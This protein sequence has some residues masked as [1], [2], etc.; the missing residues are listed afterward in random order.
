MEI[1]SYLVYL[2]ASVCFIFGIKKLSS[3][4]TARRGNQLAALGMLIAIV[5]TLLDQRILTF[6]YIILGMVVGGLVP[7]LFKVSNFQIRAISLETGLR[8][9]SLAMTITLLI[10]DSMGDFHSSMF[11]VSGMFGITMY[12]AG[13][14]AIKLYPKIFPIE[15]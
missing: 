2:V 14:V 15:K 9:A 11:W 12:L 4:K 1:I 3:P 7:A 5:V 6:E 10:Q 13:L 8:N